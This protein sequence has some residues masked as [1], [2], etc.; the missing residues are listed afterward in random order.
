MKLP[1]K[2]SVL[3]L[4]EFNPGWTYVNWVSYLA[5][6]WSAR[7]TLAIPFAFAP[8]LGRPITLRMWSKIPKKTLASQPRCWKPATSFGED[9]Q[10][11][12]KACGP[13]RSTKFFNLK[14]ALWWYTKTFHRFPVCYKFI[15]SFPFK[16]IFPSQWTSPQLVRRQQKR[17]KW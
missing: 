16:P 5:V 7:G 15:F 8:A 4:R 3:E 9:L 10:V 11:L 2:Q 12:L 17:G 6:S 1:L 13:L 14:F